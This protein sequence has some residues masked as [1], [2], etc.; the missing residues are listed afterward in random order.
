MADL[1]KVR[2]GAAKLTFGG[3]SLGHTLDEITV[4]F[5]REFQDLNVSQYGTTPIDK[6]LTGQSLTIKVKLAEPNVSQLNVALPEGSHASATN[7]RLGIGTDA[8]YLLRADAKQLVLHPYRLA[9][10]DDTE[11]ITIYKAVSSDPV[12]TGYSVDGQ[13]VYEVTFTALVDETYGS[14]RRL[15][16]VGPANIS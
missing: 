2:I 9:D 12:A 15:G 14:G 1:T 16:H 3:V 10:S 4:E 13:R 6:A 5:G 7:E 8:G 11:N